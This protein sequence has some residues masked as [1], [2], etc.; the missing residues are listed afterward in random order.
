M[1]VNAFTSGKWRAQETFAETAKISWVDKTQCSKKGVPAFTQRQGN[2][3]E[4]AKQISGGSQ[5]WRGK[6]G[7][8]Q[9]AVNAPGRL[10]QDPRGRGEDSGVDEARERE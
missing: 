1:K 9:V 2:L 8:N 4:Q 5:Q 7:S 10:R 3:S 6:S